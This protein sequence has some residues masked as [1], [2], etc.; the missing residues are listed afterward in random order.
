MYNRTVKYIIYSSLYLCIPVLYFC[1]VSLDITKIFFPGAFWAPKIQP[2][3]LSFLE[4]ST[5]FLSLSFQGIAPSWPSFERIQSGITGILRLRLPNYSGKNFSY[6]GVVPDTFFLKYRMLWHGRDLYHFQIFSR[7]L[8][9]LKS[10]T[11]HYTLLLPILSTRF[12]AALEFPY[13][14]NSSILTDGCSLGQV[15][16][17]VRQTFLYRRCLFIDP[18]VL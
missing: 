11:L 9:G 7:A 12:Q 3:C 4:L 15:V 16:G 13:K 17:F 2:N 1:N 5:I 14:T 6:T 8:R 18:T 10:Q